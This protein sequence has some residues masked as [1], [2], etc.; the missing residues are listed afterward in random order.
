MDGGCELLPLNI[1]LGLPGK[2]LHGGAQLLL[3]LHSDQAVRVQDPEI[4]SGLLV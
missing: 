4:G 2:G 1:R 3:A